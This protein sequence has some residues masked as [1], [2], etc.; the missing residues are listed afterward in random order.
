MRTWRYGDPLYGKLARLCAVLAML[1]TTVA[2]CGSDQLALPLQYTGADAASLKAGTDDYRL[3]AGDKLR[4]TV[5]GQ[6]ELTREYQIDGA[7]RLAFPLAGTMQ[8]RGMTP[9]ALEAALADKL[10]PDYIPQASVSVEVLSFR[11]FYIV[12]EVKIPGSYQYVPGM[13]V[14]N[15]VAMGGGYTYRAR[16]SNFLV[17]RPSGEGV[18]QL[19][20]TPDTPLLPGDIVTVRERYF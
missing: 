19:A 5:F 14:L 16:E 4:I 9:A 11:P 10:D 8:A 6:P 2:A 20:A 15:A 18:T 13:T 7:G 1:A 17:R 12:G 3:A